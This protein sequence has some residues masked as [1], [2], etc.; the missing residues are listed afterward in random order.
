MLIDLSELVLNTMKAAN[1]TNKCIS[2]MKLNAFDQISIEA[3]FQGFTMVE[4]MAWHQTSDKSP[5]KTKITRLGVLNVLKASMDKN[6]DHHWQQLQLLSSEENPPGT[7]VTT[8]QPTF[9]WKK[10]KCWC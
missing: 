4:G 1:D 2:K 6:V 9:Y 5:P 8:S 7:A 10:C 3:C